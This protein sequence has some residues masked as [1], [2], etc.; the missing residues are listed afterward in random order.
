M[1]EYFHLDFK[2]QLAFEQHKG[3]LESHFSYKPINYDTVYAATLTFNQIKS[4]HINFVIYYDHIDYVFEKLEFLKE[5]G[6]NLPSLIMSAPSESKWNYPDI[7]NFENTALISLQESHYWQHDKKPVILVIDNV[8]ISQEGGFFRHGR[9]DL[10]EN[11]I[12]HIAK[13]ITYN[14]THHIDETERFVK[15]NNNR[16]IRFGPVEFTIMFEYYYQSLAGREITV[17]RDPYLIITDHSESLP[18]EQLTDL[19]SN[20]CLL[21]SFFWQKAIDF[22]HAKVRLNSLPHYRTKELIKYSDHLVDKSDDAVLESKFGTFYD[23]VERVDYDRFCNHT[24]ILAEITTRIIKAKN[25]D[26]VSRFMVYYNVIEKIRNYCM[27][28]SVRDNKLSIKEEYNFTVSKGETDKTIKETIK[29]I[30]PIVNEADRDNFL[31]NANNKVNFIKKTGLLDQ[32]ESVITYLD[33]SPQDYSINFQKLVNIRNNIYHGKLPSD[34][35]EEYNLQMNI[36]IHDMLIK[37]ITY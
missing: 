34:N 9:F 6:V 16:T 35:I 14:Y 12:Q 15:Q 13:Y 7:L 5:H 8:S 11:I 28:N 17:T 29:S 37:L 33:L 36:L 23:F 26:P 30:G 20:I 25:I 2:I 24:T 3:L 1:A 4:E 19:G 27:V 18:A 22:F 32:F 31:A 10:T 21:M